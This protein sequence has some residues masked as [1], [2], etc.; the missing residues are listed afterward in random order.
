MKLN[1][2]KGQIAL[3]S[4]AII[5]DIITKL[6]IK[7]KLQYLETIPVIDG[8]F[9]IVYVLNPGAAFG[10]LRNLDDSYR[11]LFFIVVTIIAIIFIFILMNK[12]TRKLP[13]YALSLVLA[14][15]IGNLIDRIHTSY[16][17]DFLDFYIGSYHWPAFNVADICITIG[18][19]LLIIDLLFFAKKSSEN[20]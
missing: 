7:A 9:N 6:I 15:A 12:E 20:K 5:L 14:G 13:A 10:F 1:I 8:F 2:S 3:I 18:V 11:Q 17:V 4:G 16:V 19:S